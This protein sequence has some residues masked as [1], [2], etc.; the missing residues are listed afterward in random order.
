MTDVAEH[1]LAESRAFLSDYVSKIERCLEALTDEDVWWR[2]NEGSNSIGNLLLHLEGSTRW[3]ILNVT[4]GTRTPARP[5]A[6]ICRAATNPAGGI[7]D[8]AQ[9]D[10]HGSRRSVGPL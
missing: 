5:A 2:A 9:A 7:D 8:P 3:W 10:D 1:F 4:G 6:G